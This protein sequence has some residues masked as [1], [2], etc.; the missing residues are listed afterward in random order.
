MFK[1]LISALLLSAATGPAIAQSQDPIRQVLANFER[2]DID[3]DGAISR[4][5]HR[6]VQVARW[7]QID[8]NGDGY[9]SEEDFPRFAARRVRTQ[10]AQIAYLDV[11]SDGRI[12]QDEFVNGPAPLFQHADQNGDGAVTRSEVEAA[13]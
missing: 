4:A 2:I 10:L 11:N 6:N 12:S 1:I 5:E 13:R 3:G 7:P 9:L 8:R